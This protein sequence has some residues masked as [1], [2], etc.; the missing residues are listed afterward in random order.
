M[1]PEV[2]EIAA[3]VG[4]PVVLDTATPYVYVGTLK[5]WREH[6]VVLAD[7][8]VHDVSEGRSGKE[9]Y[10]LEARRHGVQHSRSE[11][12]VRKAVVVSISRLE[13]VTVY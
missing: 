4:M 5:E 10:V 3:L 7:A 13:D 8:D 11:V 12:T 9:R 6:F 2:K 1:Q